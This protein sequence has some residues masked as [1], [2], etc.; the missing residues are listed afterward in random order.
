MDAETLPPTE[1]LRFPVSLRL[2]AAIHRNFTYHAP[3]DSQPERYAAIRG[4]AK[5]LAL[6]IAQTSPEGREQAIALTH[7]ETAVFF[8]NAGIAHNE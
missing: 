6:L 3:K 8:A 7:L 2:E 4:K 5:E 1:A